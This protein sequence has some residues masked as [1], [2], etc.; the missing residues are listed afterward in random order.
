M[1]KKKSK[2]K[3]QKKKRKNIPKN[4]GAIIDK[5]A[6]YVVAILTLL[7][8]AAYVMVGGVVP[9]QRAKDNKNF[10]IINKTTIEPSKPSLQL[11]TFSG[12]TITPLPTPAPFIS[13]SPNSR[14]PSNISIPP[15]T[16]YVAKNGNDSNPGTETAPWLTIKKA[17]D[18]AVAGNTVCVKAGTY[19]DRLIPQSSGNSGSPIFFVA[20]AGVILSDQNITWQSKTAKLWEGMIEIA[21]KSYITIS[22]FNIPFSGKAGI[23]INGG[24]NITIHKNT[25]S[26][27]VLSPIKVGWTQTNNIIID[28]NTISRN[29]RT[30]GPG[31]NNGWEE[32]ISIS[33]GNNVEVRNN[34]II[35]NG[36]GECIVTKDGT[37][38][39]KVHHNT[40]D[41]CSKPGI[42]LAGFTADQTDIAAYSNL[43]KNT[44]NGGIRLGSEVGGRMSYLSVYDNIVTG[45]VGSGGIMISSYVFPEASQSLNMDNVIIHS[46]TITNS[47]QGILV[48][49]RRNG[50]NNYNVS[51]V[52]IQ[53]NLVSNNSGG[54]IV[55]KE[56]SPYLTNLTI[57]HNLVFG[58]K[59]SKEND[60]TS[61]ID[62]QDPQFADAIFHLKS[63]SPAIDK[64]TSANTAGYLDYDGKT[65]PQGGGFDIGAYEQ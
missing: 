49:G 6:I 18:T 34:Y 60:G 54:Q 14:L 56:V 48:E 7:V 22:G 13:L 1:F 23:L 33:H 31:N 3:P 63:T 59:D 25:V 55:I 11:Y 52:I 45:N 36:N 17:G 2:S 21:G 64:G 16:H 8:S 51:S 15:C 40:I 47:G 29:Y 4:R 28:S 44:T 24:N 30:G 37:S 27:A 62:G 50:N 12:S 19:D 9:S 43:V 61:V 57:D 35:K 41:S 53:N 38:H 42:Y 65:R 5:G 26:D 39:I 10:V 58:P 32:G 20:E 46:N